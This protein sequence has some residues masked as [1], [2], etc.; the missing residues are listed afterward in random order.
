MSD[1]SGKSPLDLFLV[2]CLIGIAFA[3]G[4][5]IGFVI[6]ERG[7]REEHELIS[8]A[9]ER[10][11]QTQHDAHLILAAARE[12]RML[13]RDYRERSED[14]KDMVR[15]LLEDLEKRHEEKAKDAK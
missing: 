3:A 8:A 12:D 6:S 13:A 15:R 11:Y 9:W 14:E 2:P 5:G 7:L 1:D 4:V 10:I